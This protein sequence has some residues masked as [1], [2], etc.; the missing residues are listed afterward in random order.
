MRGVDAALGVGGTVFIHNGVGCLLL[1]SLF[2]L[3]CCCVVAAAADA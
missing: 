2:W 3:C 1:L